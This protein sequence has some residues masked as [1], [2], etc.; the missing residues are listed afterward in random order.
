MDSI[1]YFTICYRIQP[2]SPFAQGVLQGSVL[3]PVSS[4]K[5]HA[6]LCH[7][8]HREGLRFHLYANDVHVYISSRS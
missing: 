3:S 4:S 1:D 7:M 6:S 5:C 2:S 8:I